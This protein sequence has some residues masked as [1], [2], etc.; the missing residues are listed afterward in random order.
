MADYAKEKKS[1]LG[2]ITTAVGL[3]DEAQSRGDSASEEKQKIAIKGLKA[4]LEIVKSNE[5]DRK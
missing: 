2:Q 1:L 5:K 4:L 3:R